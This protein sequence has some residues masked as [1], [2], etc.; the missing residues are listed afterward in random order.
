MITIDLIS[1]LH[2]HYPKL[3]GGDLLIVAGDLTRRDV[4]PEWVEFFDWLR[5]QAY[6]KKVY[7]GG[8]HDNFLTQCCSRTDPYYQWLNDLIEQDEEDKNLIYL[9]DSGTE[10]EY[11]EQEPLSPGMNSLDTYFYSKKRLKIWGSPWT[12]TFPGMNPH[13]KAFTVDTDEELAEKWLTCPNDIDIMITHSPAFGILDD[14]CVYPEG[15]CNSALYSN[16]GSKSLLVRSME[17]KPRLHVFGH[18]HECGGKQL[19]LKRAGYGTENN[20]IYVNASHV[21]ERYEPVNK[22]IRVIL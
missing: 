18:I 8:N 4:V 12:K 3:E 16:V 1:D 7:I 22:P 20:T 15:R 13:C 14:V 19:H 10:F 21:N 9:C 2:G 17:I 11:E 5:A 6:K